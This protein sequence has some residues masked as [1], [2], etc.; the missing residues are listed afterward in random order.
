[1][2]KLT[3]KAKL[4]SVNIPVSVDTFEAAQMHLEA[5]KTRIP[6]MR[7]TT[8]DQYISDVLHANHS[9]EINE[10]ILSNMEAKLNAYP[11]DDFSMPFVVGVTQDG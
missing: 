10:M 5:L 2:G 9:L 3:G 11:N 1:M 6:A 8:T 7:N 4:V